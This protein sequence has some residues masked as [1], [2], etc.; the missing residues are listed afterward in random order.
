MYL[1]SFQAHVCAR[2]RTKAWERGY[3]VL[4]PV[5]VYNQ[6]REEETQQKIGEYGRREQ[7]ILNELRE[8]EERAQR[9][10]D[11]CRSECSNAESSIRASEQQVS[12]IQS[13]I[14]SLS[15]QLTHMKQQRLKY[16]EEAGKYREAIVFLKDAVHFWSLFKQFS[17]MG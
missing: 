8:H 10:V 16:H 4:W 7:D 17:H 12:S 9:E 3:G 5:Q 14:S 11:R 1:A 6:K 15:S 13:Q 2:G